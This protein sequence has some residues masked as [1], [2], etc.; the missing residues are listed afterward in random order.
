VVVARGVVEV[1]ARVVVVATVVVSGS[2]VFDESTGR[3][4]GDDEQDNVA[5]ISNAAAVT[6]RKP[7]TYGSK[8]SGV[9]SPGT[10]GC[11]VAPAGS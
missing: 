8:Q 11:R 1:T 9:L 6:A 7:R 5:A 4:S 2:E 10:S 3:D